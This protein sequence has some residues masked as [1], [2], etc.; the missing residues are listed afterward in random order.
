LTAVKPRT[1]RVAISF[2]GTFGRYHWWIA[3]ALKM[4]VSPH[5]GTHPHQ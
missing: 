1:I 5:V 4:A 2:T 3:S